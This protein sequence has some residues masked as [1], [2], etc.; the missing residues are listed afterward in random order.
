MSRPEW[1]PEA[2]NLLAKIPFFVR[3]QARKHVEQLAMEQGYDTI[4]PELV[5]AA[6]HHFGQ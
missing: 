4:T 5:E 6:R 3:T 1:T 2:L